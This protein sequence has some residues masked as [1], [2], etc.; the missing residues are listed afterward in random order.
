[1]AIFYGDFMKYFIDNNIVVDTMDNQL[2]ITKKNSAGEIDISSAIILEDVGK[3]IFEEIQK[4]KS[5]AE[6]I[7]KI[8]STYDIDKSTAETDFDSFISQLKEEKIIYVK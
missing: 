3:F 1:M 4:G 6:I 8:L 5:K 2:I 7:K